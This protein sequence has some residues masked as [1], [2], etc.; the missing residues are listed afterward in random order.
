VPQHETRQVARAVIAILETAR[1]A[2][3]E[4]VGSITAE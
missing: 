2:E 4:E 1:I 3:E